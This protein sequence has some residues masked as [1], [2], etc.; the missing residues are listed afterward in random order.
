MKSIISGYPLVEGEGERHQFV[1]ATS[2]QCH[3]PIAKVS[4]SSVHSC[5]CQTLAERGPQTLDPWRSGKPPCCYLGVR[6]R[7][8]LLINSRESLSLIWEELMLREL[9]A[10]IPM[11]LLKV[12]N[13]CRTNTSSPRERAGCSNAQH[14]D[15]LAMNRTLHCS[16]PGAGRNW[17]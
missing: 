16:R 11:P 7:L 9:A 6:C 2:P 5:Q 10:R 3:S 4:A 8:R 13:I 12:Y 14:W 15:Q 17:E 1:V